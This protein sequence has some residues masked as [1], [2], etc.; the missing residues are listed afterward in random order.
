[1]DIQWMD[2]AMGTK[3]IAAYL[4]VSVKTVHNWRKREG[5][6]SYRI[7]TGKR[8]GKVIYMRAEVKKWLDEY[9]N[10]KHSVLI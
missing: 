3:A 9:K 4:G 1:M 2:H 6:P 5:L 10:R 8:G 7:S